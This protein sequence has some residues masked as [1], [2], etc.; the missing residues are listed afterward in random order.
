VTEHDDR[1]G[2]TASSRGESAWKE[3]K[4]G[5]AS[6]N[7]AARKEAKLRRESHERRR[8]EARRASDARRHARPPG[9]RA[10]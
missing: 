1:A 9:R 2:W 5:V 7:A 3:A 4:E 8:E 10:P 6:R